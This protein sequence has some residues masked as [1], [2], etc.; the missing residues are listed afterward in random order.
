MSQ[1]ALHDGWVLHEPLVVGQA[2]ERVTKS[3]ALT[4]AP[5]AI[6]GRRAVSGRRDRPDL[7]QRSPF[8][9]LM[10][11]PRGHADLGYGVL[12][13]VIVDHIGEYTH[14]QALRGEVPRFRHFARGHHLARIL[15]HV[16]QRVDSGFILKRPRDR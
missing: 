5:R 16:L 9:I 14:D 12:P 11:A 1:T 2:R 13:S 4:I 10:R 15:A 8:P 6:A 7:L 3:A